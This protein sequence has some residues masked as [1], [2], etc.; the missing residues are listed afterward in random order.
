MRWKFPTI[1]EETSRVVPTLNLPVDTM[2][3]RQDVTSPKQE[4]VTSPSLKQD[5]PRQEEKM[6]VEVTN[7]S[8]EPEEMEVGGATPKQEE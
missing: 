4:V 5:S 8:H 6:Q 3:P 2:S 1:N 7:S